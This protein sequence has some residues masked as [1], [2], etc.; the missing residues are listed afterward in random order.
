MGDFLRGRG[1]HSSSSCDIRGAGCE[2]L[3]SLGFLVLFECG[4]RRRGGEMA[5]YKGDVI[6]ISSCHL[7]AA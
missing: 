2:F 6:K 5:C 3:R 1:L 4:E 7:E